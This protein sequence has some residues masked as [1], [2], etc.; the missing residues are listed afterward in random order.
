MIEGHANGWGENV[1]VERTV[2]TPSKCFDVYRLLTLS[3]MLR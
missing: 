3:M 2:F 1:D